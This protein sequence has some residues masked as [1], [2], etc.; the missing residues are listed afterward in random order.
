MVDVPGLPYLTVMIEMFSLKHH[1]LSNQ[2][3]SLKRALLPTP[4]NWGVWEETPVSLRIGTVNHCHRPLVWEHFISCPSNMVAIQSTTS[5]TYG[6]T[7]YSLCFQ[8]ALLGSL[9]SN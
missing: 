3:W 9:V 5:L 7:C 8:S 6:V 4:Q 1:E 2:G